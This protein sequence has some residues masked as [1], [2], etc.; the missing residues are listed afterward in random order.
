MVKYE[1][2]LP[3]P[4]LLALAE[5]LKASPGVRLQTLRLLGRRTDEPQAVIRTLRAA[6]GEG[7]PLRSA[8]KR[9]VSSSSAM[10]ELPWRSPA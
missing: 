2:D 5:D 9:W 1:L 6:A 10:P 8:L 4:V 3:F 7:N